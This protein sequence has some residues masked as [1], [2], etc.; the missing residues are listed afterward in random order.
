MNA[1]PYIP[2]YIIEQVLGEGGMATVYMAM[3]QKL[4]RKVAIKVLDS[5]LLK[6]KNIADRFMQEAQTAANLAHPNIISIYDVDNVGK[7]YYIVMEYLDGSLKDLIK[8]SPSRR[9]PP[10][11]SLGIIRKIAPALDYAHS[12]GIIHRDIKP[13]NIMFRNDGTPVLVDFGI[14]RAMDSDLHMTKT[15]VGVGTPHYM[16]P[17]QCK[18]APL[19]GRSDFYSLGVVLYEIFTGDKPFDADTIIGVALK[20]IQEAAPQLPESLARY[21]PLMDKLLA[22]EKENRVSN[23]AELQQL[24]EEALKPPQPP[25]FELPEVTAG[26]DEKTEFAIDFQLGEEEEIIFPDIGE[27][28]D[29]G[30]SIIEE[31]P[32]EEATIEEIAI[33]E[34]LLEA[35]PIAPIPREEKKVPPVKKRKSQL[36]AVPDKIFSIPSKI[37]IPVLAVLM[38]VI[39][40]YFFYQGL[41]GNKAP[42]QQK[43]TPSTSEKQDPA[44]GTEVVQNTE[45][46]TEP[47]VVED[48][49][50]QSAE[51]LSKKVPSTRKRR[52]GPTKT[53]KPQQAPVK[54]QFSDEVTY[55]N[56]VTQNTEAAYRKYLD[57]YP[58]GRHFDAAVTKIEQLKEG[59]TLRDLQSIKT[60]RTHFLRTAYKTLSHGEVETM[61]KRNRFF[62]GSFNT[63]GSFK[64]KFEKKAAGNAVVVI[65]YRTG[66]MWHP[67]GA[68]KE[69]GYRK[70][71]K[72]IKNLNRREYAG[73]SDWRLPSL[74]EAASLLSP[75]KNN[76]GLYTDPLFSGT[77]KRIWTGDRF[78]GKSHWVVRFY[79]GI[80][81]GYSGSSVHYV[82]PVR[83]LK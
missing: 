57:D 71:D 6:I 69:M 30:E 45:E 82:R 60:K 34:T 35:T 43:E 1:F 44:P 26:S 62:E 14:A 46:V 31:A 52:T 77:Q 23:G 21:Q 13:D 7:L 65:D 18:T 64:S 54:P 32:I 49:S 53:A 63:S 68:A 83:S 56:A 4:Q 38:F 70:I 66:L 25:A 27:E 22:K 67:G 58:S 39:F 19:D 42:V 47:P 59:L 50:Q 11:E 17:E 10:K 8:S 55:Q 12:Q 41:Q 16:S 81:Y 29:A 48:T 3:Q 37:A 80:V 72:W 36:L 74:E 78:G 73:Y 15:G 76:K 51:S 24:I 40:G 2:D 33:E 9:L 61:I 28:S 20:H 5:A 75:V 79:S